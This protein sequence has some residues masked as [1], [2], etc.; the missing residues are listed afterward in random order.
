VVGAADTTRL[1][2]LPTVRR[3]IATYSGPGAWRA[4][5]VFLAA[6]FGLPLD[7][8]A[9]AIYQAHTGR[10]MAPFTEAELS[11]AKMAASTARSETASRI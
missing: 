5:R 11:E 8:D 2:H 7:E 6:L 10:T 4:W 9:W 1:R 3:F